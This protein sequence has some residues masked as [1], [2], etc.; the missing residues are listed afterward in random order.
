MRVLICLGKFFAGKHRASVQYALFEQTRNSAFLERVIELLAPA[1]AA[2]AR[3]P[4]LVDGV[5]HQE[6]GFGD[7]PSE[8]GTWADRRGAMAE[9]MRLL[10]LELERSVARDAAGAEQVVFRESRPRVA[11]ACLVSATSF[12]PG[13]PFEV[14]LAIGDASRVR[15]AVLRYRVVDQSATFQE[16]VMTLSASGLQAVIPAA[17][18]NTSYPIMFFA[19]VAID[20]DQ[21]IMVPGL[22]EGLAQWPYHVVHGERGS[23]V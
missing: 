7:R 19:E 6:L 2:F 14:S 10:R 22:D 21:P 13:Q 18:T 11:G 1:H 16:A 20:D 3:I 5:Y 8:S 15:R 17:Y 9:D 4:D 23:R 12:G